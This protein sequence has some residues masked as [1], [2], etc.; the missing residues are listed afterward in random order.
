VLR[1]L[2]YLSSQGRVKIKGVV[3]PA[4]ETDIVLVDLSPVATDMII[5]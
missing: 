3:G 5:V 4:V 2:T 1:E